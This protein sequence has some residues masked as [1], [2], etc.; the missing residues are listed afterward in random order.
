MNIIIDA[1]LE[2]EAEWI[3]T[4]KTLWTQGKVLHTSE[5]GPDAG[6]DFLL[7]V[8]GTTMDH[9][10]RHISHAILSCWAGVDRIIKNAQLPACPILRATDEGLALGMR[11]YII[12]SILLHVLK[13]P[14]YLT[15]QK[16][17]DWRPESPRLL[18]GM[19]ATVLGYGQLGSYVARTLLSLGV[20]VNAVASQSRTDE[21]GIDIFATTDC[22]HAVQ[23]RDIL[24]N[25]LPLT[26]QTKNIVNK[27]LLS[28][29]Q[30]DA[31]I[32]NSGRGP[33]IATQDLL[34]WLNRHPSAR[35]TLDVFD[36]EPLPHD[37][38][39][40]NHKQI[41]VTPHIASIS[42]PEWTLP[43]LFQRAKDFVEGKEIVGLVQRNKGY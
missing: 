25:L 4:A 42:R 40:W 41:V 12:G 13:F 26:E 7:L 14:K 27:D 31:I 36:T 24:I 8:D 35:A 33:S 30:P 43:D 29:L 39:T 17:K 5:V 21:L 38:A 23:S 32:I 15:D 10:H 1:H 3:E 2:N 9:Q 6:A 22:H 20:E 37:D 18:H 16:N 28:N 34:E 19:K 11:D